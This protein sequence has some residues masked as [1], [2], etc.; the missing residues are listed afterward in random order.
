[1]LRVPV[2]GAT[3]TLFSTLTDREHLSLYE[4]ESGMRKINDGLTS[5]KRYRRRHPERVSASKGKWKKKNPERWAEIQRKAN[6]NCSLGRGAFDHF[7]V[8]RRKQRDKCAVCRRPL[9]VRGHSDHNHETGKWR[10][11]LCG[12]C[13]RGLGYLKD[14]IKGLTAAIAYL[15]KWQA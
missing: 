13:N 11:V 4:T 9:V 10:G 12:N 5:E 1:M 8:Q 3:A 7:E 15:K 14:N 2:V 6:L